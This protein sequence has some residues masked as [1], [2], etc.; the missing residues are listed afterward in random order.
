MQLDLPSTYLP[1]N[2][3][4]YVN[5]P[6]WSQNPILPKFKAYNFTKYVTKSIKKVLIINWPDVRYNL[7]P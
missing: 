2:L 3:T 6:I 5:A 7:E 1:K 4:S